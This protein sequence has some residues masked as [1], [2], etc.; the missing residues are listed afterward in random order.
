MKR[1]ALFVVAAT[2]ITVLIFHGA[3][4]TD[5][6]SRDE[7]IQ[8]GLF[9]GDL[10]YDPSNAANSRTLTLEMRNRSSRAITLPASYDGKVLRLYGTSAENPLPLLLRGPTG[11]EKDKTVRVAPGE[12]RICFSLPLSEILSDE[13]SDRGIDEK[14]KWLWV[15]MA[16][17]KE[18]PSPSHRIRDKA[19]IS[20]AA[21]FWAEIVVDNQIL[22]TTPFILRLARN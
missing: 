16:R 19:L 14:R 3:N 13:D 10:V 8:L 5:K 17:P 9:A 7:G 22:R 1:N 18:P 2:G 4:A 12:Q 6:D 15:W 20:T 11:K 21:V